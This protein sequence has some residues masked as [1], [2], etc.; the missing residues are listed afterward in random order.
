MTIA[1]RSDIIAK[2]NYLT[3]VIDLDYNY[4][5]HT[6][7]C[8]HATGTDEEYVRRA[9]KG[10]IKYMGFSDHMP[11]KF[12][13]GT[14][15]W[16][17]IP[18]SEGKSYC[19]DIKAL[20]K[21]YKSEIDITVGFE[22]EYYPEYFDSMLK[23]ALDY[24]GEYLILGQHYTFAEDKWKKHTNDGNESVDDLRDYVSVI[25]NGMKTGVFTYVAHPDMYYFVGDEAIY[26]AEMRRICIASRELNVPIEINCQGIY[27]K[28][29]YPC[30]A[31]WQVA[32]EEESPVVIGF[33]SHTAE[34]AYD[35][36]SLKRAEEIIE[37]YK[38][39]HIGKPKL[40]KIKEICK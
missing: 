40:V 23:D 37:K 6:Y 14:E 8:H 39:N 33:D 3:E 1:L 24:G 17:R 22:M 18:V 35:E 16:Y 10:G 7:R 19:D 11:L 13:D 27:K 30:E 4:H 5:T 29:N 38:L 32:G 25:I 20:A 36:E 12:P 28:R 9:T 34:N 26:K 31:F 2:V 21:K 15:S